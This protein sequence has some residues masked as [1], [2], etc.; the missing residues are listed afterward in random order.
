MS[1]V[2]VLVVLSTYMCVSTYVYMIAGLSGTTFF[3]LFFHVNLCSGLGVFGGFITPALPIT[4][5]M[6]GG[7]LAVLCCPC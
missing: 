5:V 6:S 1:E 7:G 2:L 3:F 4:A